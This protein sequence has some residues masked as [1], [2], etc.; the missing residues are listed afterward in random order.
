[1]SELEILGVSMRVQTILASTTKNNTV[2]KGSTIS[3]D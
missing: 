3:V 1:M 2:L